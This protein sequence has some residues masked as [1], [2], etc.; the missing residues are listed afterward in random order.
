MKKALIYSAVIGAMTVISPIQAVEFDGFLTAGF[1]LHDQE[2]ITYLDGI[3][4][5]ISFDQDSK[6]GLQVT[7]DV[8]EDMQVVAQILAAGRD[9]NFDM[10]VEWAYLD[11][12]ISEMLSLR[13]GK[14]KEPVF[15]ISDYFEV[16]YA[17][18]WIRPPQEVYTA[19]P[20]NTINGMEI[21]LQTRVAG[22][23]LSLQPYLGSNTEAIPGTQGAGIFNAESFF[24]AALQ[25]ASPSFT[26]QLS[27]L[28]T[29]V[30]TS[31]FVPAGTTPG[32]SS[33][34][35]FNLAATGEA[36]L[37]SAGISVDINNL[38]GYA[39][40]VTRE[41]TG[42]VSALFPNQDAYYL[43]FGYRMGKFLPHLTIAN[44]DSDTAVAAD[45]ANGF[46][47][48]NSVIQDSITLG[49]RYELNDSATLKME[50][51]IVDIDLTNPINDQAAV[52]TAVGAPGAVSAGSGL[53]Q[54]R[55]VVAEDST[56]II[57]V[58]IDVIF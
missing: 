48:A 33:I 11:Y 58:A 42:T 10:D 52:D 49:L 22:F 19:N 2:D 53:F 21:L 45:G 1:S 46:S 38:V 44:S 36:E 40:F 39:E 26:F 7:A 18:P 56:G 4:D 9:D 55:S 28:N 31:G 12:K 43:T 54:P 23:N 17:Y 6:F 57:S 16:G 41:I 47:V 37:V 35:F 34:E 51:M 25:M 15:L 14:I 13:G 8:S 32:L 5:D 24:G 30:V 50:Y 3:T 20:I 27:F 29:D